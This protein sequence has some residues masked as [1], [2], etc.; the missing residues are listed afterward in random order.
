MIVIIVKGRPVSVNSSSRNKTRWKDTVAAEAKK[1]CANP[2]SDTDL[3]VNIRFFYKTFPDFDTDNM[4]KPICDALKGIAYHDDNQL[5]DCNG[6]R[7]NI[8]GQFTLENA[9]PKVI[10]AITDEEEF[11][12]ITIKK[13]DSGV[14]KI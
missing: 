5:M 1:V 2:L 6:G 13:D 12:C 8:K 14:V 7:T 4:Y 3:I 10:D 11:V 9:D